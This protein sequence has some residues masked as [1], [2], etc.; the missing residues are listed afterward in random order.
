MQ[1]SRLI[2]WSAL[3]ASVALLVPACGRQTLDLLPQD[4]SELSPAPEGGSS[5]VA[6]DTSNP[7]A[8][9]G[10]D[11][12]GAAGDPDF[13]CSGSDCDRRCLGDPLYCEICRLDRECSEIPSFCNP[14]PARCGGCG[15]NA[16]CDPGLF[17]D[18]THRCTAFCAEPSVCPDHLPRCNG[19][20]CVECTQH[21]QCQGRFGTGICVAGLCAECVR[22]EDCPAVLPACQPRTLTCVQ[23]VIDED[24]PEHAEC[25]VGH[26][27]LD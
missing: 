12:G 3:S 5:G 20:V 14:V 18:V 21:S 8:T 27:V 19:S 1:S 25:R 24:C 15:D 23:C 13:A 22:D 7:T 9:A 17:C 11:Q 10:A 16:D 4:G 2:L 26:C 6:G